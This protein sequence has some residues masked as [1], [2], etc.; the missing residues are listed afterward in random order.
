M[1]PSGYVL[2]NFDLRPNWLKAKES[3]LGK[4]IRR[5]LCQCK[6]FTGVSL[7]ITAVYKK[8]ITG[9]FRAPEHGAAGDIFLRN[10]GEEKGRMM[11]GKIL[12]PSERKTATGIH[13]KR[14]PWNFGHHRDR[15]MV[16]GPKSLSVSISDIAINILIGAEAG[17]TISAA[18]SH[19]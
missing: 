6:G 7:W 17:F 11:A 19:G 4:D 14:L 15:G 3:R 2:I 12:L 9:M 18:Q 1:P 13:E 5:E 16:N 8:I 10:R